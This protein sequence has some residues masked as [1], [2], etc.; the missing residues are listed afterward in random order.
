MK[1][2]YPQCRIERPIRTFYPCNF[3]D[4][5]TSAYQYAR[6]VCDIFRMIANNAIRPDYREVTY[7]SRTFSD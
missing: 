6:P 7:Y 4:A 2:S 5:A 3:T 1:I